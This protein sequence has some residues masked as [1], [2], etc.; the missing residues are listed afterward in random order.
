MDDRALA[1]AAAQGDQQAFAA[2][3]EQYRRLI[4]S[5][6][7][8]IT[9]NAEDALDVTQSVYLKMA[10]RI[11]SYSGRGSF[12]SWLATIASREAIDVCRRGHRREMTIED[13]T[14]EALANDRAAPRPG[15][16][17]V[18]DLER[19]RQWVEAAMESLSPQ[20]RAIFVLRLRED[21]RPKDIAEQLGIPPGHVRVQLHRAIA[22]IRQTLRARGQLE[23]EP[24][25]EKAQ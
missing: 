13:D 2:L 25:K 23:N 12:K 22:K 6:A 3:V 24:V 21:E 5:I 14:L 19:R 15:P 11:G 1:R 20:Q 9:L 17:E 4:Y 7:W 8:R 18:I 16:R 10:E